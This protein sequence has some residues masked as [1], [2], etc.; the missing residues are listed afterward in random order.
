MGPCKNEFIIPNP[1]KP[2]ITSCITLVLGLEPIQLE[3]ILEIVGTLETP[4]QHHPY[5][6]SDRPRKRESMDARCWI[7]HRRICP[8]AEVRRRGRRLAAD[9]NRLRNRPLARGEPN[10]RTGVRGLRGT[11][12]ER[13][14][15]KLSLEYIFSH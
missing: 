1:Q 12:R 2:K 11:G 7:T 5:R 15:K 4:E 8:P 10:R 3:I 6:N 13:E 14:N 9:S